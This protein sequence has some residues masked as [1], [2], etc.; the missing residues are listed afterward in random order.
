MKLFECDDDREFSRMAL[1]R[2]G[3]VLK[4]TMRGWLFWRDSE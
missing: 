3:A 2:A 1:R 4:G